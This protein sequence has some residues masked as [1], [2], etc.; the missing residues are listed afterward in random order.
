M[1]AL[2]LHYFHPVIRV[3]L[4]NVTAAI[5]NQGLMIE[6]TTNLKIVFSFVVVILEILAVIL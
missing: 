3:S 1:G 2:T 5:A 6:N 4:S